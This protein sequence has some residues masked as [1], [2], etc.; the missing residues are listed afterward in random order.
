MHI[1]RVDIRSD[2]FPSKELY[3]FNVR[4]LARTTEITFRSNVTIFVGDNGSGKSTLIEAMAKRAGIHIWR[5]FQRARFNRNRYEDALH[6]FLRIEWTD[7]IVP[8]SFFASEM[9]KSFSLLVDEWASSD[10]GVLKYF[11]DSSLMTQSHGQSHMAF[12][13]N[14]FNRT[15]VYLLDE[16]ENALSPRTQLELAS[17]INRATDAGDA[18]FIMATHSPILLS[19]ERAD[20]V[21]FDTAPVS[22]T[23]FEDTE[24]YRVYENFFRSHFRRSNS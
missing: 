18:Q 17:V 23:R 4:S 12:F 6:N 24:H 16:P 22:R 20:L 15:G 10:P 14:R 11:G 13:E 8:G 2:L 3:P 7:G 19:M 1:S 5:G 21:S 9:F